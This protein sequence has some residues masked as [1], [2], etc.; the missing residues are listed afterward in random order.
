MQT[1]LHSIA[2]S[3]PR[4]FHLYFLV[5]DT[6][7]CVPTRR[8]QQGGK[9]VILNPTFNH[10][11][12]SLFVVH[13][14]QIPSSYFSSSRMNFR[15]H[16]TTLSQKHP[17]EIGLQYHRQGK[18]ARVKSAYTHTGGKAQWQIDK[19]VT[20]HHPSLSR[21]STHQLILTLPSSSSHSTSIVSGSLLISYHTVPIS[22]L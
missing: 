17:S 12:S 7:A 15:S 14:V 6:T 5:L 1:A 11:H 3:S 16:K 13:R 22:T 2:P 8:K 21:V 18:E 19:I 20:N 10:V 9:W 4:Y